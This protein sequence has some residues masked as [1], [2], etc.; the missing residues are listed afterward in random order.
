M[1]NLQDSRQ[2]LET[3]FNKK[4][5]AEQLKKLEDANITARLRTICNGIRF[6]IIFA[7]I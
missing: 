5:P 6:R 7:T 3:M 1:E 4:Y 2:V